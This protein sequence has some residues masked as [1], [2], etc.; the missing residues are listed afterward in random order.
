MIDDTNQEWVEFRAVLDRWRELGSRVLSNGAELICPVPHVAPEAWFHCVYPP[1]AETDVQ[2][3]EADLG[4][5]LPP[6]LKALYRCSNG[7]NVF[8][9]AV[10]VY[11]HRR[12]YK[13]S[14]DDA[15]QPYEIRDS[16]SRSAPAGWQRG[17]YLIVGGYKQDGSHLLYPN[18]EQPSVAR[19]DRAT[20]QVM[21]RWPSLW[22][23]LKEEVGRLATL[24][25]ADG[26]KLS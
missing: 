3:L 9:D 15:W 19:V 12:N 1:L 20:G 17:D 26:R 25:D 24:Y 6:D 21:A 4:C 7:L 11:G 10:R 16:N 8:S 14:G 22:S 23:W 18:T 5:R 2:V 13:R